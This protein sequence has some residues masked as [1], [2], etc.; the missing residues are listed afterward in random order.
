MG[1][2]FTVYGYSDTVAKT[3]ADKNEL[4]FVPL[5]D[6]FMLGDVDDNGIVNITDA[7]LIQKYCA[8]LVGESDINLD[9]ADVNNDGNVNIADATAIQKMLV[10]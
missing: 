6:T 1:K 2:A 7:T 3:Y 4:R 8:K 10:A 5:D 9:V